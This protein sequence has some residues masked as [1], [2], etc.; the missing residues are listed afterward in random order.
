MTI[1]GVPA[2]V[3][4]C[5][6]RARRRQGWWVCAFGVGAT[7]SVAQALL[8]PQVTLQ[9]SGLSAVYGLV[10][11]LV[12]GFVVIRVDLAITGPR[13]GRARRAEEAAAGRP[14]PARTQPLL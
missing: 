4:G 14:E 1:L 8:N 3:W 10:V 13:S 12:I 2:L 11:G 6:M 5:H 7:A 9:E